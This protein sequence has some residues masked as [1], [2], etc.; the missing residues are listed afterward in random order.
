MSPCVIL[1]KEGVAKQDGAPRRT[2]GRRPCPDGIV[3]GR[4]L[5]HRWNML[6]EESERAEPS[7]RA[8]L[9]NSLQKIPFIR[10]HIWTSSF[11]FDSTPI[12]NLVTIYDD[13]MM[14]T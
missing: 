10:L 4:R 8:P 11:S 9:V 3:R 2:D 12:I 7:P 14:M 13:D 6:R 1:G 5:M